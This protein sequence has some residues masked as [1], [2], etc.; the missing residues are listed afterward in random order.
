MSGN[1]LVGQ[2]QPADKTGLPETTLR[3]PGDIVLSRKQ[4][5]DETGFAEVTPRETDNTLLSPKQLADKIGLTKETIR[6]WRWLRK[7]PPFQRISPRCIRYNLGKVLKWIE[8]HTVNP[9]EDDKLKKG[10]KDEEG[11]KGK[12]SEK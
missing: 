3:K 10:K 4:S 12:K 1:S 7:G 2:K 6:D 5:T 9:I 11:G 8:D